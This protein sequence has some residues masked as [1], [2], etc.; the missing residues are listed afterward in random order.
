VNFFQIGGVIFCV[1]M[2]ILSIEA[3]VRHKLRRLTGTMWSGFWT[4]SALAIIW[5][6]FTGIVANFLG[7]GRGT[8]LV[9]YGGLLVTSIGFFFF[10][11][12]FRQLEANL[13]KIVR[14]LAI[15]ET[16]ETKEITVAE[17]R[18]ETTSKELSN[19]L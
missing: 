12:R 19:V 17:K 2:I 4:F 18:S 5:P 9:M 8:D 13:T 15:K 6:N 11:L 3:I 16:K 7:I 14:H 1:F 10:Y